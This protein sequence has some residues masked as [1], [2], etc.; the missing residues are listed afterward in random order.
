M[1]KFWRL[2]F[3]VEK[4]A[5]RERQLLRKPHSKYFAQF[6]GGFCRFWQGRRQF[7]WLSPKYFESGSLLRIFHVY[8]FF[9]GNQA[10]MEKSWIYLSK[11]SSKTWLYKWYV[12]GLSISPTFSTIFSTVNPIF[13]HYGLISRKKKVYMKNAEERAGFKTF[14]QKSWKLTSSLSK[15]TKTI[16]KLCKLFTVWFPK[17]LTMSGYFQNLLGS[18]QTISPILIFIFFGRHSM[19][20][21]DFFFE[22][23]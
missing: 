7:P 3:K 21:Q 15:S 2:I 6:S 16:E 9:S 10:S 17:E 20:F 5:S 19:D 8:T 4:S 22:I 12:F 14:W 1:L 23:H 13:L 18:G 11:M